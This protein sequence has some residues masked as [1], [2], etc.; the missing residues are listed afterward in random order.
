M[1][2]GGETREQRLRRR[3][4]YLWGKRRALEE[5][6]ALRHSTAARLWGGRKKILASK[7]TQVGLLSGAG[8]QDRG[9]RRG[10]GWIRVPRWEKVGQGSGPGAGFPFGN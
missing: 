5:R 2:A 4:P 7:G 6:R 1:Q 8:T 10:W 3:R 9:Q